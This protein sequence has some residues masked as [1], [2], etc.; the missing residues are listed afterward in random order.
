MQDVDRVT[1]VQPLPEPA[2]ARRP[3]VNPKTLLVVTLSDRSD[4]ITGH[5]SRCRHLWQRVAIRP[6]ELE[7]PVGPARDL[8]ALLV[9]RAMMPGTEHREVGQR[10]RAPVRPVAEMMPLAEA[11]PA[12]REPAAL[13]PMM[14]RPS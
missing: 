12:A 1:H 9:H 10:R 7:R 5:R 8:E 11:D 2:G 13:V 6:P 14:K 4:W 3:R